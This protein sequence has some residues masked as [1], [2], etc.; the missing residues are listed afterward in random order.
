MISAQ[1]L[2]VCRE[3][4]RYPLCADAALRVQIM[5]YSREHRDD[6]GKMMELAVMIR[7]IRA[8]WGNREPDWREVEPN[9]AGTGGSC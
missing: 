3:E 9:E 1:T 4:N 5:L 6:T 8:C 7:P 2:R